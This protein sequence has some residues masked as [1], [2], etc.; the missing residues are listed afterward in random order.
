V[1]ENVQIAAFFDLDGTLMPLPSLEQRFFRALRYRRE[2][3]LKN[4]LLWLREAFRLLPRGIRIVKHANKMHLKGA[5]F[6]DE[7]DAENRDGFSAH[8]SGH[9]GEGQASAP[10]EGT[11]RWPVPRFF[12]EGLARVAWHAAQG[13]AILLVTGTLEP[14]AN[15][16]ARELQAQ[17]AARGTA[18]TVRVCATRLEKI[19][20]QWTGRIIGEA[21]FGEAKA[22]AMKKLAKECTLELWRCFA[23]GDSINDQAML[24]SVGN[25]IAVNP[26]RKLIRI[27]KKRGWPVLHWSEERNLTQRSRAHRER[28][29]REEGKPTHKSV[30]RQGEPCS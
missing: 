28:E 27:V 20:G 7:R 12:G 6:F 29:I 11:S 5:Q 19:R 18:V 25:P 26:S 23:Y 24:A 3:P 16:A 22:R 14:L 10:P 17:L 13:H 8:N 21:M 1:T 30:L 2:I 4:Y 9:H 15:A